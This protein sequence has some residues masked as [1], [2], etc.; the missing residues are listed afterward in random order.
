MKSA[1]QIMVSISL[2]L[3]M[4]GSG[5]EEDIGNI[6]LTSRERIRI[7]TLAKQKIDSLVPVMD[8]ICI[9]R[10]DS[11][12]ARALDSILTTRRAEEQKIRSRIQQ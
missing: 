1:K 11:L 12:R 8:S 9:A 10:Y 4:L 5:C 3:L 6:R 7:D 2:A